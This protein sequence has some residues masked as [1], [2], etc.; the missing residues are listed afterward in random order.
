MVKLATAA[1][2]VAMV[3]G[4]TS[5]STGPTVL[6][7]LAS[8]ELADLGPVL[9]QLRQ[10]TGIELRMTHEGTVSASA[11]VAAGSAGHDLAWLSSDHLLRLRTEQLPLRENIMMSPLVIGLEPAAA[12]RLRAAARGEPTWAD[13]AGL[14]AAGELRYVLSDPRVSG[15]GLFTLIGAAT[16][17]AGTGAALRPEDVRCDRLRSFLTGRAASAGSAEQPAAEYARVHG[18]VDAV[19]AYESTLVSL[20]ASKSLPEPLELVYPRD[21]VV[22]AD[23]PLMLLD[24]GKRTAYDTAVAWLRGPDGQRAIMRTTA[25]RPV[26]PAVERPE[27][28]ARPLGTG[29]YFPGRQEVVD[30]LLA[31]YDR[32]GEPVRIVYVLDYSTSMRGPRIAGLRRTF[33]VLAGHGGFEQFHV[34]E[35]VTVL[36]FAG[37][38]LEERTT[39][40]AG[41]PDLDALRASVSANDLTDG[42]AIWSALDRAYRVAGKGNVIVVTDGENNTGMTPQEFTAAWPTPPVPTWVVRLDGADPVRLADVATRT[43]GRAVDADA[44]SLLTALRSIRG[45]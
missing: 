31:A 42:T 34:G 7:V 2:A 43:G 32:A 25:R 23:Y 11:R 17:A 39:T 5:G 33:E 12:A 45:C 37:T 19:V 9:T 36:R 1:A 13:V 27:A 24:T 18:D 30:A 22:L 16:A 6:T 8:A 29:L 38:V 40:V 4:C 44:D 10:E 21:G 28:L 41:R 14:A 26:D 15:S 20:N 35:T 3:A